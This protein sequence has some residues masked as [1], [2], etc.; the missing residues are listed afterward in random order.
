MKKT[1]QRVIVLEEQNNVITEEST[2]LRNN[3]REVEKYSLETPEKCTAEN[4]PRKVRD[5]HTN[6]AHEKIEYSKCAFV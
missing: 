2:D 3:F 1:R 6:M 4:S 5:T